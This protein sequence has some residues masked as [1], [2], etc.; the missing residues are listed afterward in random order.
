MVLYIVK[1]QPMTCPRRLTVS[2]CQKRCLFPREKG[3]YITMP[4]TS[5]Q[6]CSRVEKG[7]VQEMPPGPVSSRATGPFL[8][9][10]AVAMKNCMFDLSV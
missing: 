7:K 10:T 5:Q 1:S 9:S 4:S 6:A 2:S 3:I 8:S